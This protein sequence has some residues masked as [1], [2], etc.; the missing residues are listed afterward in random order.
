MDACICR[1][2]I[3]S[4]QCTKGESMPVMLVICIFLCSNK[5][6]LNL[7]LNRY[8]ESAPLVVSHTGWDFSS[9]RLWL[10]TRP[11]EVLVLQS[12]NLL[13]TSFDITGSIG[14][15]IC[16]L[17][18]SASQLVITVVNVFF[19]SNRT[20]Q[21]SLGWFR[22]LPPFLRLTKHRRSDRGPVLRSDGMLSTVYRWWFGHL[23]LLCS[24]GRLVWVE[25]ISYW[26]SYDP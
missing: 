26:K 16:C 4:V 7:N 1:R 10:N 23:N 24:F 21:K 25:E 15:I 13:A 12:W 18:P 19:L 5:L 20:S 8:I 14:E 9:Y 2:P 17:C 3:N 6:L 11:S 22:C